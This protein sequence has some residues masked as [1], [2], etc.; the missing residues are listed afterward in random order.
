M[1]NGVPAAVQEQAS[2]EIATADQLRDRM[3][4]VI[5]GDSVFQRAFAIATVRVGHLARYYLR[6][7]DLYI[8]Q[9]SKP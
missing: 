7:L 4:D 5:P 3:S 9:E 1:L 8:K 2:E 6:A